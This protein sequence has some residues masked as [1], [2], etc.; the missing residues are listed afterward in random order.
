MDESF[1]VDDPGRDT[2]PWFGWA[3]TTFGEAVRDWLDR[4]G[5]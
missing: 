4:S 1:D 3:N 2:P 5:R